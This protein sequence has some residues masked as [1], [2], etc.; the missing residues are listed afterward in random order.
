MQMYYLRKITV[1]QKGYI[2][3]MNEHKD[4]LLHE[5]LHRFNTL[6]KA[7]DDIWQDAARKSGLP[8]TAFWI[9]YILTTEDKSELTQAELC[10]TWFIPR[11]TCNSAVKKLEREGLIS[12]TTHKGA[13]NIK[14][15]S[16]TKDGI[17]YAKKYITPL[18]NADVLSFSSFTEDERELLLSLMQRQLDYL[19]KG[20]EKL[21]K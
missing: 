10:D 12:L 7:Q 18:T 17:A 5:Q 9:I 14:Y 21:W 3:Y 16:L 6:W 1:K 2:S 15:L 13:G 8:E 4:S 19:K 20:T 11:Q